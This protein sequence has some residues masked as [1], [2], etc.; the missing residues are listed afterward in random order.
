M[1]ADSIRARLDESRLPVLPAGIPYLLTVLTDEEIAINELA[2]ILE[3][4]PTIVARLIALANSAWSSPASDVT[5]LEMACARLGF[6]IIRSVSIALAIA[7]PFDPNRCQA[8]DA[9][10]YWCSALLTA[11]AATWLSPLSQVAYAPEPE[12]ARVGGLLHN[13]GLL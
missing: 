6:N 4:F 10:R 1:E 12:T 2:R 8:F 5:S 7:Q 13:L 3:R 9:E 11:D